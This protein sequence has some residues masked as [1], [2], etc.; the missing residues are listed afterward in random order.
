MQKR[1]AD[2][3]NHVMEAIWNASALDI[4]S[5]IRKVCDK[6][7]HDF[8]V[9]KEVR[10]RRARGLEVLG[11]IF[12]EVKA[13]EGKGDRMRDVEEAMRKAF[14]GDEGDGEGSDDES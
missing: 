6:V 11:R 7:L 2:V 3:L 9:S 10:G 5:T 13:P 8:A 12:Q 4:E 1:Q 14:M